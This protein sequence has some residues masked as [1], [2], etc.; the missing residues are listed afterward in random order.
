MFQTPTSITG[1]PEDLV[2][3]DLAWQT[4]SVTG[5]EIRTAFN[6]PWAS[7]F[8]LLAQRARWEAA[9][10]TFPS[11]VR[12]N[13]SGDVPL[14]ALRACAQALTQAWNS[15]VSVPPVLRFT[16]LLN[17]ASE[18]SVGIVDRRFEVEATLAASARA[19]QPPKRPVPDHPHHR[20]S[21]PGAST[22][23]PTHARLARDL[24]DMTGLGA[25]TLGGTFGISREQY[26]RW[27]SGKPISDIRYGQLQ[28]LH[29]VVREL[30][31]RLGTSEARAWL[32]KPLGDLKTPVDLLRGRQLDRFYHE[33]TAI[34]GSESPAPITS[35][36][37]TAPVPTS[38]DLQDQGDPWTPYDSAKEP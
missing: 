38:E 26:S 13:L 36:S 31:R 5:S 15:N 7:Q 2:S 27:I 25:S 22:A 19:L 17:E 37:L 8:Q 11:I 6:D 33:V 28:F 35:I 29:T 23:S 4:A 12:L 14:T 30:I 21:P 20:P 32:H 1:Y 10:A 34:S 18:L 16:A 3:R 24:R 9:N